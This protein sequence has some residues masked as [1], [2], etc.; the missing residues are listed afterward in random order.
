MSHPEDDL[1]GPECWLVLRAL[2]GPQ[3]SVSRLGR[4]LG[5]PPAFVNVPRADGSVRCSRYLE[6]FFV[7]DGLL[8]DRFVLGLVAGLGA[9]TAPR[10][11]AV[12]A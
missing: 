6:R 12:P 9:A 4:T 3:L 1:A 11:V 7:E 2:E 8:E 10:L 5:G